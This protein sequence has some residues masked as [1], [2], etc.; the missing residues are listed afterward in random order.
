LSRLAGL[1]AFA[2]W[3]AAEGRIAAYRSLPEVVGACRD[4]TPEN[5]DA[6]L[7]ALLR[8]ANDDPLAAIASASL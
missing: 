3:A 7:G 6:L 8:V 4:G 2:R 1:Q 5:Q